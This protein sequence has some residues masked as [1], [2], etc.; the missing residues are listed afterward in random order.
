LLDIV[1]LGLASLDVLIRLNTMPCWEHSGGVSNFGL[2]GGGP[3]GTACV[4]AAKLGAK[5]GFI[6]TA[7]NDENADLKL[8]SF[9]N[10][11][12]DLSNLVIRASPENKIV[13]VYIHEKTGERIF[14]SVHSA[15]RQTIKPEEIDRIYLTSAKYL[16][17]DGFEGASLE[18]TSW[19]RQ[20]GKHV[21]LDGHAT[22]GPLSDD[23]RVLVSQTDYLICGSGF[24]EALTG[25][26][27]V[28]EACKAALKLGP[29]VVVQ[30]EGADGSY[31]VS[32]NGDCF[33]T[34]AFD[35]TVLDTTG[36]GDV[37][38]GAYLVG[39]VHGWDIRKTTLFS[40]AVSAIK[41]TRLGG[42]KGIP[43]FMETIQ[44]LHHRGIHEFNDQ[45]IG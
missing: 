16:L 29:A 24:T 5:V 6:G 35:V 4:A 3:A 43:T 14:Y 18:A 2:D 44:F 42:R 11:G 30:T 9:R 36:A 28:W 40:T 38:H 25:Y 34:P 27:D 37:F 39:L 21:M 31:T 10:A 1:G 32:Q 13:L 19:M 45:I 15:N 26:P 23:M 22:R 33:H 12:V 17:I 7:G 20:A 8:Q 41:C